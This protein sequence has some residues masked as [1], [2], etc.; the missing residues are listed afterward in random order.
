MAENSGVNMS[1]SLIMWPA[2]LKSEI[3]RACLTYLGIYCWNMSKCCQNMACL[4]LIWLVSSGFIWFHLLCIAMHFFSVC[5]IIFPANR[6][7]AGPGTLPLWRAAARGW[8]PFAWWGGADA[9]GCARRRECRGVSVIERSASKQSEDAPENWCCLHFC[10]GIW[11]LRCP[12][13]VWTVSAG[14]T[15]AWCVD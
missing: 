9:V 5:F 7:V 2:N 15:K 13:H 12:C 14:K 10:Y 3:H 11:R 6:S 4:G 1:R 8:P